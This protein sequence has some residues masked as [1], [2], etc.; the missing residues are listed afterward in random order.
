MTLRDWTS[1]GSDALTYCAADVTAERTTSSIYIARAASPDAA[2]AELRLRLPVVPTDTPSVVSTE[3][4]VKARG[5]KL[6][7]AYRTGNSAAPYRYLVFDTSR[8]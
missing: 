4:R 2:T 8:L 3:A 5:N 7:L 6:V 1:G